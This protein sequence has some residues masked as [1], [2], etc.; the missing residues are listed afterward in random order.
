[1]VDTSN[2]YYVVTSRRGG[3]LAH[4]TSVPTIEQILRTNQVW[5][6]NPLYMNDMQEMRAVTH[7]N[8]DNSRGTASLM[9]AS[10]EKVGAAELTIREM[11]TV[12]AGLGEGARSRVGKPAGAPLH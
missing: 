9:N 3:L 2:D 1:M 6:S 4:Y 12:V 11:L 8:N 7:K 10:M 5:L